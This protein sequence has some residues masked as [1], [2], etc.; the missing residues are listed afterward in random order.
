MSRIPNTFAS[1]ET[2]KKRLL[3]KL[4]KGE[5]LYHSC[6]KHYFKLPWERKE[7]STWN[8]GLNFLYILPPDH[9]FGGSY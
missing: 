1:A 2:E 4:Q 3:M 8:G 6:S 5:L 7:T 9:F